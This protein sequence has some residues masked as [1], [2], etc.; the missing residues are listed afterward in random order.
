MDRL[1]LIR[2]K[3]E[4]IRREMSIFSVRDFVRIFKVLPKTARAFLSYH[5][6]DGV[7]RRVKMGIYVLPSNPP[8]KFELA[9]YLYRPSYISFE[10]ALSYYGII[11]ETVYSVT[12]A[13]TKSTKD[14][15]FLNL[16]YRYHK[17]K[18]ELFFG[19]VPVKI[20]SRIILIADR[21]K[22]VLDYL[23][24]LSLKRQPVNER[25]N[26]NKIDKKKF[27]RY[28]NYFKKRIRKIDTLINIVK[29]LD[30]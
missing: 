8:T 22:A 11:P 6:T 10:S 29:E 20:R 14:F 28:I 13:T 25:L 12:S 18:K 4:L 2:V 24:L 17:I 15:N 21:E 1:N 9:N 30:L 26:L 16:D 3:E 19:F 27:G 23:Y 7:F 5:S